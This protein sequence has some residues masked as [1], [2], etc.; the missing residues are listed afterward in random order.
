M[1]RLKYNH[2]LYFNIFQRRFWSNEIIAKKLI[3]VQFSNCSQFK[4][5][6]KFF[7]DLWVKPA[8]KDYI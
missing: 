3:F 4:P 8:S 2:V 1:G 5:F 7:L 6:E